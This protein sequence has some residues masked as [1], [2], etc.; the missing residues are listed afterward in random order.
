MVP[1]G[2]SLYALQL[3][4]APPPNTLSRCVCLRNELPEKTEANIENEAASGGGGVREAEDTGGQTALAETA[5]ASATAS[6]PETALVS[7]ETI[8]GLPPPE[9]TEAE[10]AEAADMDVDDTG[11]LPKLTLKDDSKYHDGDQ[12]PFTGRGLFVEDDSPPEG[13]VD[14]S[15]SDVVGGVP[16][17]KCSVTRSDGKLSYEGDIVNGERT[18]ECTHLL[19]D[20][21]HGNG[22]YDGFIFAGVVKNGLPDGLGTMTNPI[23]GEKKEAVY[24]LVPD[25]S[26]EESGPSDEE[27][28][29]SDEESGPSDA[30]SGAVRRGVR[31]VRRGVRAVRRGVRAVRRGVNG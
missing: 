31:A 10:P 4:R 5:S 22:E 14:T 18:G 16:N 27:S 26:D 28:G 11:S 21:D 2:G 24:K 8:G 23:T 25:S 15:V 17:G 20:E 6:Q 3:A 9:I 7:E 12:G 13:A 30:E 29:P 1:S 19:I